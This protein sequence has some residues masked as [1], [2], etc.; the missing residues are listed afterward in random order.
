[1]N[2]GEA[3]HQKAQKSQSSRAGQLEEKA[4]IAQLMGDAEYIE[5][6]QLAENEAWML[7]I[8]EEIAKYKARAEDYGKHDTKSV[9]G[10]S[11]LSND[12]IE[13]AQRCHPRNIAQ[14]S[15]N[16][17]RSNTLQKDNDAIYDIGH[18]RG[19]MRTQCVN[20]QQHVNSLRR[21]N[22]VIVAEMMCKLL[23]QASAPELCILIFLGKTSLLR[24]IYVL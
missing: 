4:R 15:L 6:K 17:H 19:R 24:S 21:N 1:M 13:L 18:D 8:Q 7:K 5:Q 10:R 22:D 2:Q 23:N 3:S 16:Y 12:K 14:S 20:G 11:Q 9:D